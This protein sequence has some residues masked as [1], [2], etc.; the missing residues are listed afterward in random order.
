MNILGNTSCQHARPA[1]RCHAS[2]ALG[3]D[4]RALLP[5][6]W[7]KQ[8]VAPAIFSRFRDYEIAAERVVGYEFE[9]QPCY[10]E[11]RVVLADLR[12]DDDEEYY[13][14]PNYWEHLVA[15]RLVDGRWL[16]HRHIAFGD[17]CRQTQSFFTFAEQMPR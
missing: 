6:G 15:W 12:S 11:H 10:C 2:T 7:A 16:I 14:A 5:K 3:P 8:V 4:W 13:L 9:D 17:S 1:E